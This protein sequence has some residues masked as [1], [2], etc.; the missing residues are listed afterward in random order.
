MQ[1]LK[2]IDPGF[3]VCTAVNS[4]MADCRSLVGQVDVN[5]ASGLIRC[6][7]VVI[8]GGGSNQGPAGEGVGSL[9]LFL[10]QPGLLCCSNITVERCDRRQAYKSFRY[11]LQLCCGR[12]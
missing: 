8:A 1:A 3:E 11:V 7:H 10:D 2:L 9:R 4:Q 6:R 12:Q 5:A